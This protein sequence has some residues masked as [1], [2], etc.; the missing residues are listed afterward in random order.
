[1]KAIVLLLFSLLCAHGALMDSKAM[2]L[3]KE[4]A[5]KFS[6][7]GLIKG[8][9]AVAG[10][11]AGVKLLKK[12]SEAPYAT[13]HKAAMMLLGEHTRAVGM[14]A[15]IYKGSKSDPNGGH[16]TGDTEM[17]ARYGHN[18]VSV[19]SRGKACPLRACSRAPLSRTSC[20]D[21]CSAAGGVRERFRDGT[22]REPGW[23]RCWLCCHSPDA[24]GV[25]GEVS[26]PVPFQD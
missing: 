8:A 5:K 11:V 10:A 15:K 21:F 26:L 24:R 20:V 2:M 1:M 3:H 23:D 14:P 9:V 16:G 19:P 17:M 18:G 22:A 7:G 13:Q 12:A 6:I 4:E 25:N